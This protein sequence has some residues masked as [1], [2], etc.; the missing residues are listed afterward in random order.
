MRG[1]AHI[2]AYNENSYKRGKKTRGMRK[3]HTKKFHGT[4]G[5]PFFFF[6][7]F[8][9]WDNIKAGMGRGKH[10]ETGGWRMVQE[11]KGI[12]ERVFTSH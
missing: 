2:H 5:V 9:V 4:S 10:T 7:L 6:R 8:G 3:K 11:E 1:G 12:S